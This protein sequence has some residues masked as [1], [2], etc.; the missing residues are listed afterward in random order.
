MKPTDYSNYHKPR[1]KPVAYLL[2][3][4]IDAWQGVQDAHVL[5]EQA[6]RGRGDLVLALDCLVLLIGV[7][8]L[9][10]D[11]RDVQHVRVRED[12][13]E[14]VRL[15][16]SVTALADVV[17]HQGRAGKGKMSGCTLLRLYE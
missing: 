5:L 17:L 1:I 2:A 8:A 3:N 10:L 14:V 13:L 6:Q 16:H 11:A 9:A 12:R 15:H 4:L 7:E